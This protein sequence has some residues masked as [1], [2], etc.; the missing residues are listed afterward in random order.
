M[1]NA[2]CRPIQDLRIARWREQSS[3]RFSLRLNS[4]SC[5]NSSSR[6]LLLRLPFPPLPHLSLLAEPHQE[7]QRGRQPKYDQRLQHIIISVILPAISIIF[8][9]NPAAASRVP[10]VETTETIV[11]IIGTRELG[12]VVFEISGEEVDEP[13]GEGVAFTRG[14]VV[15]V[16]SCNM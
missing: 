6:L 5:S 2:S 13:F 7:R 11:A 4:S 16:M 3:L 8:V 14:W 15:L 1:S 10:F 12:F 9:S